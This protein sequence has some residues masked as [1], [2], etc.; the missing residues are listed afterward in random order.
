MTILSYHLF[1]QGELLS[2]TRTVTTNENTYFINAN[3][4]GFSIGY[5]FGKRLDGFR[6][7]LYEA[8]FSYL[9][10]PKE[11][12]TENPY[13]QNQKKFVFGKLYSVFALRS[14]IGYQRELFSIFDK[15]GVAIRYNYLLGGSLALLKPIYYEV[16]DSTKIYDNVQ[17][18]YISDKQF[19]YSIHQVSDIY[20]RS[21]FLLGI[22]ETKFVPGIF[23]KGGL[24]FAIS[25]SQRSINS[26]DVGCI[27]DYFFKPIQIMA[28]EK[29]EQIFITLYLGYRF[30]KVKLKNE[31]TN[32]LEIDNYDN[33]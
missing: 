27:V 11:I 18:I 32:S 22:N 33:N 10:H 13:Y 25:Q 1:S 21:S 3:S 16:V 24:S 29:K 31:N 19:N 23:V 8:S 26:I 15:G 30:G 17:Y 28:T 2:E 14:G 20:S 5:T 9:K 7:R 6:K 4:N 12:R